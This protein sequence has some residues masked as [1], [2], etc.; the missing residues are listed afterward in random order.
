M[1]TPLAARHNS[2]EAF[3]VRPCVFDVSIRALRREVCVARTTGLRASPIR[4]ARD[5]GATGVRNA[6]V[7]L[8]E[9]MGAA[10][11]L[12]KSANGYR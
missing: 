9:R 8:G 1:L 7:F 4:A 12:L 3:L 2:L 11:G 10:F 5:R 6:H